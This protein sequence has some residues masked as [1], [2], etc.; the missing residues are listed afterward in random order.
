MEFNPTQDNKLVPATIPTQF[1]PVPKKI[2]VPPAPGEIITSFRTQNT[3]TIGSSIGEGNF[4]MVYSCTDTWNNELAVKVLKPRGLPYDKIKAAAEA[5][6]IKLVALRHPSITYIY[7]AFEYRDTFYIVTERC[8]GPVSGLFNLPNFDGQQWIMPI[9]RCLLQAVHFLHINGLVHQDIHLGNV[10]TTFVKDEMP[11][12]DKAIQFKLAD[13]GVAK[14]F[15]EVDGQ[16]T[17]NNL[18][19]PPEVLRPAEYGPMDYHIDLYHVGL[20]LLQLACSKEMSFSEEE[21]LAG[22]PREMA[23]A[24]PPP[25]NFALSKA[26]RRHVPARTSSAM[27]L[28][29]DLNT[30]MP[31]TP[32]ELQAPV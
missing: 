24:L 18:I 29:R 27:E 20:L 11:T 16:N 32:P 31:T 25:L 6:F 8:L 9:A 22:K 17:R 28:W 19:L 14:L 23:E 30:S 10:F 15:Q 13:M 12:D 1:L 21:I 26:L 4:G 3:Y 7:D 2:F 5:E